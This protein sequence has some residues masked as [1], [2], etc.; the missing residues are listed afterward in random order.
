MHE[1]KLELKIMEEATAVKKC[2]HGA[3]ARRW[4]EWRGINQDVL[5]EQMKI[6]QAALSGYENSE[7]LKPDIIEKLAKALDIPEQ[8]ITELSQETTVNIIANT[9]QNHSAINNYPTINNP[10]DKIIELYE[11]K[12]SLYERMIKA[13][14]EKVALLQEVLKDKK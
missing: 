4:R 9:F 14:Q 2:N 8:A 1:N 5:A 12:A 7:T 13:E 6:S 3:N 10:I 11:E